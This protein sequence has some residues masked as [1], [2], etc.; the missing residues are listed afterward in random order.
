M[1]RGLSCGVVGRADRP[2]DRRLP[3]LRRRA[4][5]AALVRPDVRPFLP[6]AP[7]APA[8]PAD[9]GLEYEA[10]R[11]TTEDGVTLSGWLDSRRRARRGPR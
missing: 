5:L 6:D 11:F 4:R 3:G 7:D 10:V 9:I 1:I 2:A 8:T